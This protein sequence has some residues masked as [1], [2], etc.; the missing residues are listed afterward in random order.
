MKASHLLIFAV[1][2]SFFFIS[3]SADDEPINPQQ[4][5]PGTWKPVEKQYLDSTGKIKRTIVDDESECLRESTWTFTEN[6]FNLQDFTDF[7]GGGCDYNSHKQSGSWGKTEGTYYFFY[8]G[9]F[10]FSEAFEILHLSRNKMS[11]KLMGTSINED[12][13]IMI[14]EKVRDEATVIVTS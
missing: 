3:C 10:M 7:K 13:V 5:I 2:F 12:P 8:S 9:G 11:L 6:L 4:L 14:F 1:V